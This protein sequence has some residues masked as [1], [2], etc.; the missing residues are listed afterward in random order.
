MT[1][2]G[3]DANY[4]VTRHDL[5]KFRDEHYYNENVLNPTGRKVLGRLPEADPFLEPDKEFVFVG[6]F[7][8]AKAASED[9]QKIAVL[10][11]L[12]YYPP[13]ALVVQ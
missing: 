7:D 1:R 8:G 3:E 10:N 2:M 9:Q 12:G 4:A 11:V 5:F 13:A 6:R